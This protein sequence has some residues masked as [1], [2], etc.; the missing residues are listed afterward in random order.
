MTMTTATTL[1]PRDL[2]VEFHGY[3]FPLEH[4]ACDFC[5]GTEFH[6]F[7]D[8]MRHALN[9]PTVFCKNC[10]L[11]M[12]NPRPTAEANSLFYARLYNRFHKR[13]APL[14]PGSPYVVK[15]RKLA[16]P[17]VDCLAQF[18]DPQRDASVFEIGTG[19]GQF[20]VASR[21]RTAW[22]VRGLEPGNEQAA[23]CRKLGL[24]VAHDFFQSMPIDDE[25]LDA[26]V[27]FHVLE[28]VDS[29]SQF[30]RHVNRI[31]KPGGLVHLEVPNLARWGEAGLG[32][33]F[34][35]PHLFSFTAITLRNYLV[36]VGGL[37]PI[38]SAQRAGSLTMI[39][40]K[41]GP[42]ATEPIKAGDFERFDVLNFM[43]RLRMMERVH[44]LAGWIPPL[45]ILRKLRSTLDSI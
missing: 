28:H 16:L 10:G 25:S 22:R 44:K 5:A 21:E 17:R 38:Y 11:C 34:Q 18:L 20:Q 19:V 43:Q 1:S 45:P 40:R 13:E 39:A 14:G 9:L 30:L 32:D 2:C 26:V 41:V 36:A 31:L 29:P 8:R 4:V 3:R 27:S 23:L 7:W 37:R 42:A 15:S 6:P 33:F 35:F 24:D 12:T